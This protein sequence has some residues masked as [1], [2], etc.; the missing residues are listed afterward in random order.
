MN[1]QQL[2]YILAVADY[3]HFGR[4]A[5][6]CH[7][8][9]PTL[10]TMIKKLEEELAV[11]I[12]DRHEQPI[13]PTATGRLILEQ[14]RIIIRQVDNLQQIVAEQRQA[15]A[16]QVRIGIIPTL[17]PYLVPRFLPPFLTQYPDVQLQ[18]TEA[19][20]ATLIQQLRDNHIDIAILV[21]PLAGEDLRV[22]PLFYEEFFVYTRHP[23]PKAYM[24]AEDIDPDRLWILEEGHCFRSQ[25]LN[26]CALN[27]ARS[28][29]VEYRSGS[30][31]TL[32]RLV[33]VED[34]L[35]ILPEL[36]TLE[37]SPAEQ[38]RLK[39]FYPP[40]PV[41][42]VS[43]VV[44]QDFIRKGILQA[45]CTTIEEVVPAAMRERRERHVVEVGER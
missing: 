24:M 12:F 14:A 44:H 17:A 39:P 37:F 20:T 41:R 36:A 8:T 7:V 40:A 30:I 25:I 3:Q 19:I 42:E 29:R 33:E 28:F 11:K 10:S 6:A 15:F 32:K 34:G 21:T 26:I 38:A 13:Q 9:Q 5:E 22:R 2:E 43:L 31:E 45:L 1:I 23:Y 4:A 35:T 27:R 16:G 18:I